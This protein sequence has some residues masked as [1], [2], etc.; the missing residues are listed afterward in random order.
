MTSIQPEDR[1]PFVEGLLVHLGPPAALLAWLAVAGRTFENL[2]VGFATLSALTMLVVYALERG[3]PTVRLD[4]PDR[5]A[6]GF[7]LVV[8]FVQGVGL[9]G[10][11]VAG[12]WWLG[13]RVWPYAEVWG[14]WSA[15]VV[16]VALDDFAYYAMHRWLYHSR[17]RHWLL[18]WCRRIH[19]RHHTVTHLDFLRGNV[20]SL[21][22]TAISSFQIPLGVI[23][24][25]MGM[26]LV[27]ALVAYALVLMFQVTDHVN[28]TLNLGPLRHVFIDNHAHKL[29]HCKGGG[30]LNYAV[31]FTLWDRL[32]GTYH[33]DWGVSPS[34]MYRDGISLRTAM[35]RRD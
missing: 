25:I 12:V 8:A 33:E 5:R 22:D 19:A 27:D 29:H 15:I 28:Y 13:T 30:R 23:A 9:G 18:R 20:A 26:G 35:E 2:L 6:I 16:A 24:V 10:A 4:P 31:V 17:G 34:Q 21:T 32:L 3:R 7:G 11:V 14:G 1:N